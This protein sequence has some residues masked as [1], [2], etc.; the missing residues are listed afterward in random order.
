MDDKERDEGSEHIHVN[1]QTNDTNH[2]IKNNEKNELNGTKE[3]FQEVYNKITKSIIEL[4][5]ALSKLS[6]IKKE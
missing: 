4:D 5:E 6:S 3:A 1:D 2:E